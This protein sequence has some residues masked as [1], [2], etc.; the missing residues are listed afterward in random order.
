MYQSKCGTAG[1]H[2]DFCV[3][4]RKISSGLGAK[5]CLCQLFNTW[6]R[7]GELVDKVTEAVKIANELRP[8]LAIDGEFQLDAAINPA[9]AQKK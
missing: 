7:T 4:Y 6:K 8:D 5:M 3:R 1:K 2:C 9:V